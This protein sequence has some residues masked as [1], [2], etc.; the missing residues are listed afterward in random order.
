VK[1]KRV[2]CDEIWSFVYATAKNVEAAKKAS[3]GAGDCWTWTAIDADT[4]LMVACMVG[5]RDADYA[6]AFDV[7]FGQLVKSYGTS[8]GAVGRYSP[9]ECVSAEKRRSSGSL[10]LTTSAPRTLSAA[11]SPCG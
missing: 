10:I 8:E 2:R 1:A 3:P 9:G 11:T 7:D 5:K 4:K 6:N